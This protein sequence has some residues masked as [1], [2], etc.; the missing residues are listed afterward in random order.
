MAE[1]DYELACQYAES[2]ARRVRERGT[3][4]RWAFIRSWDT[5]PPPM[6][7]LLRGGRGGTVRLKLYLAFLWFAVAPPHDV[8]YPA[9]AWAGLLG[10]PDPERNGARRITDAIG[11]L[12][13]HELVRVERR[14]GRPTRVLLN[15]EDQ[16]GE[17]Y[18]PPAE[19]VRRL[20]DSG[21]AGE[22]LHRHFYIQLP[23]QFWT[24]GWGV[25]LTGP[26]LAMMLALLQ[27]L[28]DR[29]A[30][31]TE[32]W[33]SPAE[34]KKR[35]GVSEDT[36]IAGFRQLSD[37]GLIDVHRRSVNRDVFDFRRM[38]NVYRLHPARLEDPAPQASP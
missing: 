34:A 6:A 30:A 10:L 28:G 20:R 19:D 9:R 38:R 33:F 14:R 2:I 29:P 7:Q 24:Q 12:A 5:T 11:W 8:A 32:L 36:R 37:L 31:T 35:F 15:R 23:Y 22:D 27:E 25:T 21:I 4:V 1:P 17:P 18:L 13:N 3:P 26:A 16:S